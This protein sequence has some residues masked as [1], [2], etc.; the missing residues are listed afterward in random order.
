MSMRGLQDGPVAGAAA[1]VARQRVQRL[2]AR[3]I[4]AAAAA[5]Q[6]EQAHHEAGRAKAA[7]RA[8]ALQ[9]R[10]LGRV[11]GAV[12]AGEV[13]GRPHRHA[14]HA[15][16]QADAAVDGRQCAAPRR[17]PLAHGHGAGAAVAAGAAFLD[18][19]AAQGLAQ[20]LQQGAVGRDVRQRDNFAATHQAQRNW[21]RLGATGMASSMVQFRPWRDAGPDRGKTTPEHL[22]YPSARP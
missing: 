2:V 11:Q 12:G 19:G 13:L 18:G 14:V 8:V 20:Q 9:Q 17:R 6:H 16:R 3:D 5:V 4:A 22:A 7:L 21:G 15:V 1:Q 10:A